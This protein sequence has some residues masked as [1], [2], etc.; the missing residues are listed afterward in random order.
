M[1][2]PRKF[3]E[4]RVV[5]AAMEVFWDRGYRETS[6]E[7]LCAGTG[8]GRGSLYNTFG[9]KHE[10]FLRALRA[11]YETGTAVQ[12][13]F[14]EGPGPVKGRLRALMMWAV[15]E[16]LTGHRR[17]G[18]FAINSAMEMAASDSEVKAVVRRHFARVEDMLE[19]VIAEGQRSGELGTARSPRSAARHL[20]SA[21]YGLRV[22][23]RAYEDRQ[24][25]VDIAE[26]ALSAL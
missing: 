17:R 23:S 13:E 2:R 9:S 10:L 14:L 25:L 5:A 12:Q 22:L 19:A 15:D 8:L 26:G 20:M 24:V 4:D 3:E 6:A 18:C 16:D 1:A 11:Y 21:Y 7:D